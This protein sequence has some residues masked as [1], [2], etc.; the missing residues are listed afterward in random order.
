MDGLVTMCPMH[1]PASRCRAG[2]EHCGQRDNKHPLKKTSDLTI[3]NV[4]GLLHSLP[5]DRVQEWTGGVGLRSTSFAGTALDFDNH[6]N[7]AEF[8]WQ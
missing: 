2:T 1:P 3:H 6:A 7:C 4:F 5:A 8:L